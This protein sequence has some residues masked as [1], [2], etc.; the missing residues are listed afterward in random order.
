MALKAHYLD[1][2]RQLHICLGISDEKQE[3]EKKPRPFKRYESPFGLFVNVRQ[4][5]GKMI[6]G[7][8]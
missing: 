4:L 8:I 3:D 6:I 7:L 5:V 2:I 1:E